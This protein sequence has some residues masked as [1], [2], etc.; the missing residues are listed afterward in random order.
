MITP[1]HTSYTPKWGLRCIP[2][3]SKWPLYRNI[4]TKGLFWEKN[5]HKCTILAQTVIK[6][7]GGPK[8]AE[9]E[10]G[11]VR[12]DLNSWCTISSWS[13][14]MEKFSRDAFY[15]MW[16]IM[17]RHGILAQIH[18]SEIASKFEGILEIKAVCTLFAEGSV[19][20]PIFRCFLHLLHHKNHSCFSVLPTQVTSRL[21]SP[22]FL[23][24]TPASLNPS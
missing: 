8:P 21:P 3:H 16:K 15:S 14:Y 18:T 5:I 6:V 19:G 10:E 9:Y 7:Q 22:P 1:L 13:Y 17:A 24:L 2:S 11:F 23:S 12:L 4:N 20:D